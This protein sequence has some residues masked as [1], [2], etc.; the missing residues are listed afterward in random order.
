MS[1]YKAVKLELKKK[2]LYKKYKDEKHPPYMK[3]ASEA[4]IEI[5]RSKTNSERKLAKNIDSEKKSFYAYVLSRSRAKTTVSTLIDSHGVTTVQ[6]HDL[7]ECFAKSWH[8]ELVEGFLINWK[9]EW[10]NGRKQKVCVTKQSEF[11]M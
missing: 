3:A 11:S 5:R 7:A 9:K 2:K 8:V 6:P 10:L 4:S 1:Y